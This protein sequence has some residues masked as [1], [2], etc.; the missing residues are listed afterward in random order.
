MITAR[1][2]VCRASPASSAGALRGLTG[3]V[4]A[5][6]AARA[7]QHSRYGGVVRAVVITR[8]PRRIPAARST[9]ASPPTRW[10]ASAKLIVVSSVRSQVPS[11]SRPAAAASSRGI[12][13]AYSEAGP[14]MP[15]TIRCCRGGNA[16][17]AL[18]LACAG[19]L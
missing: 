10:A 12:V 9:S 4:T 3:T 8:S 14:V 7:S 16:S 18:G 11:G 2:W 19:E 13:P 1:G 5:P 6:S 15:E 17:T